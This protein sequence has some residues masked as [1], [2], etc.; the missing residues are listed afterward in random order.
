MFLTAR[1][2]GVVAGDEVFLD[3]WRRDGGAGIELT[4]EG[5]GSSDWDCD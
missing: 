4:M 2:I 5:G 1:T 3:D